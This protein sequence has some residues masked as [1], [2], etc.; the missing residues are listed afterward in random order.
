M[1]FE[2]SF[3]K[4]ERVSFETALKDKHDPNNSL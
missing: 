3:E 4:L 1:T 2:R